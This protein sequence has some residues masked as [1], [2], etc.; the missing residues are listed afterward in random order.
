MPKCTV[1]YI[2]V[3]CH[4]RL[5]K[6][7]FLSRTVKV[8]PFIF[9]SERREWNDERQYRARASAMLSAAHERGMDAVGWEDTG[10]RKAQSRLQGKQD[11]LRTDRD[12][13]WDTTEHWGTGGRGWRRWGRGRKLQNTGVGSRNW[14][15]EVE[16]GHR[17]G[18]RYKSKAKTPLK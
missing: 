6:H 12:A 2:K 15:E 8:S 16:V 10:V 17:V 18:Q 11:S 5:T 4:N 9:T 3:H 13:R 1:L 14:K 7:F